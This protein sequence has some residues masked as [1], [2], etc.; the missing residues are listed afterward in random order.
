VSEGYT[1]KP[2]ARTTDFAG[3]IELLS[4]A[5]T[6]GG[7]YQWSDS[8]RALIGYLKSRWP[9]MSEEDQELEEDFDEDLDEDGWEE[10]SDE[11]GF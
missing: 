11:D 10:D 9:L 6:F 3:K 8:P 4:N 2:P 5:T 1:I 7:K